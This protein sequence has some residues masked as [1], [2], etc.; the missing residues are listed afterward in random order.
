MLN[1]KWY[2]E[3]HINLT[4]GRMLMRHDT[5]SVLYARKTLYECVEQQDKG[6]IDDKFTTI[7]SWDI[8]EVCVG[9]ATDTRIRVF[10]WCV[11][12]FTISAFTCSPTRKE[13]HVCKT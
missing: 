9:N 4:S 11:F 3:E 2:T 13:N 6:N 1:G 10:M 12:L 7:S 8:G 5:S